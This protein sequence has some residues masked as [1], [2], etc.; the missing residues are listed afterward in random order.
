MK[1]L[2]KKLIY[3]IF[4]IILVIVGIVIGT[5]RL[6]EDKNKLS[7]S[8]KEWI[9]AN[10]NIVQN[11]YVI[12]DVDVFGKNGSGV[13]F[14]YIDSM[15]KEYNLEMNPI[16]YNGGEQPGDRAFK[17]VNKL[18]KDQVLFYTEHYVLISKEKKI[19][20]SINDVGTS[21]V[22]ITKSDEDSF[23]NYL[24]SKELQVVSYETIT[25]LLQALDAGTDIQFAVIPL[26]ENLSSLLTSSYV[27][28]YHISDYNK[29]FVYQ[30]IQDDVLSNII[31]KY[32]YKYKDKELSE[33]INSNELKTF[34]TALSITDKDLKSIQSKRYNYGFINHSP[35]EV[36][37]SGS[38]GGI[39]SEYI[40]M[41]SK[42]SDTDFLFTRYKTYNKLLDAINNKK[43]DMFFN[44]YQMDTKFN[45]VD[46]L[47]Y[48]NYV[49]VAPEKNDLV[50]NSISGIGKKTVYVL[51]NSKL[52]KYLE[53]LGIKTKTYETPSDLKKIIRKENII[54]LDKLSF[55]YYSNNIMSNYNSRF[56][57][58]IDDTYNFYISDDNELL[59]LLFN[60]YVSILDP[61]EMKVKGL[62]NHSVTIESGTLVGN[63]A[64]YSLVI[65]LAIIIIVFMVYKSTKR[66]KIAKKIKKVDKIKYIDQLTS[67]KN[68]NYLN[69]NLSS[70]NKNT[71]YPQATIVL[72]LNRLQEI[73]DTDGYEKGDKQI[74]AAAN[75]LVRTQ[76]D[77]SD[78]IRTD[79][80]EFLLYLVGYSEKQV[81]SYIRKLNK[82]FKK[83]PYDYGV[84]IGYSMLLNDAKTLEDAINE[85]VEDMKNKKSEIEESKNA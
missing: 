27:I 46:S 43:I 31:E 52:E 12:N 82:E 2:N 64:R 67:L 54:V 42:F 19:V 62:Y 50:I 84:A 72:D 45:V 29:Y 83:L 10:N 70:W 24:G 85:S 37:T 6:L 40:S 81:A 48:I 4:I 9:V 78:I 79:G 59:R 23:K 68:R 73:N 53:G 32:Y 18:G 15:K 36:L 35:Y 66:I 17:V 63:I 75:V 28:D 1:K 25:Q 71:I 8:E 60:K 49:V 21:K 80:N 57:G 55:D 38:Y 58:R 16:T 77:N 14:D 11:L 22:G 20:N 51:K 7:V 65:L 74:K 26:E 56:E 41:F 30:K 61:R 47:E 39:V 34:V 3:I 5:I 13:F 69:D 76:L 44:Y 33:S